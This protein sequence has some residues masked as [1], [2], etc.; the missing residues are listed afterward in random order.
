MCGALMDPKRASSK[1]LRPSRLWKWAW[2]HPG[3]VM[4]GAML[5]AALL[6][7]RPHVKNQPPIDIDA[8]ETPLF[9]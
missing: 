4:V 7:P 6:V 2:Q 5:L 1:R 3:T 8:D 9:I